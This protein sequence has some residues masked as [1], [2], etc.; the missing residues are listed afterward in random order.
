MKNLYQCCLDCCNV[1]KF[2]SICE[3]SSGYFVINS[4]KF[5]KGASNILERKR[6]EWFVIV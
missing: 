2:A 6:K 5:A 3:G 4:I 1:I